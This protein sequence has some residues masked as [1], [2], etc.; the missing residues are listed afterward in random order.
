MFLLTLLFIF[1]CLYCLLSGKSPNAV[2]GEQLFYLLGY[3]FTLVFGEGVVK[4]ITGMKK[5]ISA[6]KQ[7]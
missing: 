6:N 1:Q 5:E 3:T 2:L 7:P 4:D